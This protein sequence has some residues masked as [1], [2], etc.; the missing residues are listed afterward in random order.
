MSK[1]QAII[2]GA[3][4]IECFLSDMK[5]AGKDEQKQALTALHY[6]ESL[7][8]IPEQMMQ[9]IS[10]KEANLLTDAA[11]CLDDCLILMMPEEFEPESKDEAL[12]RFHEG[13]GR[14]TRIATLADKLREESAKSPHR[15]STGRPHTDAP[16]QASPP[17]RTAR[18]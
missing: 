16:R 12:T 9:A 13:G 7:V 2:L 6:E 11:R 17:A 15:L 8:G 10:E 18:L 1:D 5:S 14:L 3:K 4:M